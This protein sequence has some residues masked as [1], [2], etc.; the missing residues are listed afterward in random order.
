ME[1]ETLI[2]SL[3]QSK[4]QVWRNPPSN[5]HARGTPELR[6]CRGGGAGYAVSDSPDDA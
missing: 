3:N 5:N 2:Q 1:E 6:L 4:S